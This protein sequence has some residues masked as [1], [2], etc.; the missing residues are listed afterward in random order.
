MG[1]LTINYEKINVYTCRFDLIICFANNSTINEKQ[2]K[3]L[4]NEKI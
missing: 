3:S 1:Q 4:V 2:L